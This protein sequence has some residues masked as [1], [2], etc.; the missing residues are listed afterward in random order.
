M[1]AD[2]MFL[3]ITNTAF[4]DYGT[5]NGTDNINGVYLPGDYPIEFTVTDPC[6]NDITTSFVLSIRDLEA[7]QAVC[8]PAETLILDGSGNGSLQPADIDDGSVDNCGKAVSVI[9]FDV[10][11]P[12]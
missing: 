10:G 8:S 4:A 1:C 11:K 9:L 3:I 5:G 6:G 2:D 12:L 7:P